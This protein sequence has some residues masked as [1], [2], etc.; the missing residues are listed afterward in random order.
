LRI[1][2]AGDEARRRIERDLHDGAQQRFLAATVALR[3][4]RARVA[5]GKEDARELLDQ[6]H[7]ELLLALDELRKLAQGIHPA[8]L[9]ERGLGPAISAVARRS[10]IPVTVTE[11]PTRR[12]PTAV[13]V[14]GYY[15]V[16]EALTNVAKYADASSATVRAVESDGVLLVEVSDDGVGGADPEHGSGIRGLIDRLDVLG[17]RLRVD[18]PRGRGTTLVATIPLS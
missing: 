12:L 11:V 15:V 16:A 2:E 6:V 18:S 9:T 7:D 13:E 14:A 8:V 17:G 4:A 5:D 10:S 3:L 1:V